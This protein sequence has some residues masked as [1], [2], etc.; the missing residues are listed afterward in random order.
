MRKSLVG[1][2]MLFTAFGSVHAAQFLNE[3]YISFTG[4]TQQHIIVL[5]D[6]RLAVE[7]DDM[8]FL[9][10]GPQKS[11][12]EGTAWTN[13]VVYYQFDSSVDAD[14]GGVLSGDGAAR[15]T[16]FRNAADEW[17][18]TVPGLTFVEGMGAG[19]LHPREKC[20]RQQFV[21]GG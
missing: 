9:V 5:P 8:R 11:V 19:K 10:R 13:G 18:N 12:S 3:P 21:R 1:C 16:A 20:R 17:E 14:D 4:E 2:I 15:R 6:G 7:I